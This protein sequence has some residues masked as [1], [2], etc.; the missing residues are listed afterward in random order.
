M[1]VLPVGQKQNVWLIEEHDLGASVWQL[2]LPGGKVDDTT[3]EGICRQAE[4][5]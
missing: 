1:F 3:P 4:V 5:E 2:T